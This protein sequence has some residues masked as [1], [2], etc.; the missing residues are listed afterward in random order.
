MK[1][2]YL[3]EDDADDR[4]FFE[5]ALKKINIPTQLTCA[6]DGVE[7]MNTLENVTTPPPPPH[8]VFLDLNMPL[9]DGFKCLQEIRTTPILKEIPVVI[10][11]TTGS[12]HAINKTYEDGANYFVCKPRSFDLLVK[13]IEMVLTLDLWKTPQPSKDKF[14]LSIT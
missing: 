5:D 2:I 10:F 12:D 4:M 14:V 3:A 1:I 8:I 6:H 11:S 13:A 7:L 9:K